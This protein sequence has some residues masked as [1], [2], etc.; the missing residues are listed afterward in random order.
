[1]IGFDPLIEKARQAAIKETGKQAVFHFAILTLNVLLFAGIMQGIATTGTTLA[2]STQ[3]QSILIGIVAFSTLAIIASAIS[4][5]VGHYKAYLHIQ[6]IMRSDNNITDKAKDI[7]KNK[8]TLIKKAKT[9]RFLAKT[10]GAI[11]A[12]TIIPLGLSF[13]PTIPMEISLT[14]LSLLLI[15]VAA[16][17]IAVLMYNVEEK[18]PSKG[19]EG[20]SEHP[21][22]KFLLDLGNKVYNL[23]DKTPAEVYTKELGEALPTTLNEGGKAAWGKAEA[24]LKGTIKTVTTGMTGT[25]ASLANKLRNSDQPKTAST[26]QKRGKKKSPKKEKKRT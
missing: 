26:S 6:S 7:E 11:G 25:L 13:L 21:V 8:K 19:A 9:G 2:A 24:G 1:M 15:A 20:E 10:L 12:I 16:I 17:L 14:V 22:N 4:F 5:G 3:I 23:I 18:A